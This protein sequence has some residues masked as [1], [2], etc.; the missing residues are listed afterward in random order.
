MLWGWRRRAWW[1]LVPAL[2]V[3]GGLLLGQARTTGAAVDPP[4]TEDFAISDCTFINR[5]Q[6]TYFVL[7]PGFQLVLG[8]PVEGRGEQVTI[9]VLDQIQRVAGI[10]TRVIE[11]RETEDGELIEV[12]RNFFAICRE[13]G[14]VYYFGEDVDIYRR[15]TV[16]DHEG[17]WRAGENGAKPGLIMP[18]SPLVGARYYQEIAPGVALDRAEILSISETCATPAGTFTRCLVT[19]ESTP[20]APQERDQKLYA[21]GIGLIQDASLKLIRHSPRPPRAGTL[22]RPSAVQPVPPPADAGPTRR[23]F[24]ESGHTLSGGFLAYWESHGGLAIF[25]LPLTEEFREIN[26]AD[27]KEYTVQYFERARFE[28]HPEKAG[29][30]FEVELGLLGRQ[31]LTQRGWLP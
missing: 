9:T 13:T 16:V 11:E 31:L 4:F 21:P 1:T 28:H 7:E 18:G 26:P 3:I 20:L 27:G 5:G 22:A 30:P 12:S 2:A 19:Q 17:A 25:G 23:Y 10:D 14:D 6:S 24:A 15:G 8:G 29:S